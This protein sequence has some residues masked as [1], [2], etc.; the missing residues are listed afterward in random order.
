MA[1]QRPDIMPIIRDFD[2]LGA[3]G[4]DIYDRVN[5]LLRID[6]V[7]LT[8]SSV[9]LK[10]T[11][12]SPE[13]FGAGEFWADNIHVPKE[14]PLQ[15]HTVLWNTQ[16]RLP[17]VNQLC[18]LRNVRNW[19]VNGIN[20]EF[21]CQSIFMMHPKP[22][23]GEGDTTTLRWLE[24]FGGGFGGWKSAIRFLQTFSPFDNVRCVAVEH[25]I[26]AA[27]S[28]ALTHETGVVQSADPLPWDFFTVDQREW[29]ICDDVKSPKWL[30][31]ISHLGIDAVSISSPCPPWSSAGSA[32]G[33]AKEEGC[34]MLESILNCRFIKPSIIL[35]EQVANFAMHPHRAIITRALHGIGFRIVFQR[36]LNLHDVL[37][38]DRP[39]W[40]AL[41]VRVHSHIEVATVPSWIASELNVP[42]IDAVFHCWQSDTMQQLELT[43]DAIAIA[44]D[45][46]YLKS[47]DRVQ[48]SDPLKARTHAPGDIIPTFMRMY[49][50]QHELDPSNIVTAAQVLPLALATFKAFWPSDLSINHVMQQFLDSCW[51]SN[52]TCFQ[53]IDGGFFMS[54]LVEPIPPSL[55][56]E[57]ESLLLMVHAD[58]Q[59]DICW[60]PSP[61]C[62]DVPPGQC[63]PTMITMPTPMEVDDQTESATAT[64]QVI[65]KAK[66]C[67][68][69]GHQMF[70]FTSDM[71]Y[72]MMHVPWD[73]LFTPVA[74][75]LGELGAPTVELRY[76]PDRYVPEPV[77]SPMMIVLDDADV[78]LVQMPPAMPMIQ[79]AS[80]RHFPIPCDQFGPVEHDKQPDDH[81]I[82]MSMPLPPA[83]LPVL[84][85]LVVAAAAECRVTRAWNP[86]NDNFLI[87]IQG[88]T[89]PKQTL[90]DFWAGVLTPQMLQVLGRQVHVQCS[91]NQILISFQPSRTHGVCP[92]KPFQVTLAVSATRVMLDE[93]TKDMSSGRVLQLGWMQS[94]LWQGHFPADEAL[95][96]VKQ[97][98]HVTMLPYF[99]TKS[100]VMCSG[101]T[102][103]ASTHTLDSLQ[104]DALPVTVKLVATDGLTLRLQG[105]GGSKNQQRVY[106]QS[107]LASMLLEQGYD[108]KWTTQTVEA[109]LER[110]GLGKV[111]SITSQPMGGARLKQ[112]MQLLQEAKIELPKVDKPVSK[113][114]SDGLPW[115][116]KRKKHEDRPVDPLEFEICP[117]FF[118]GEDGSPLVQMSDIRPQANGL[119]LMSGSQATPWLQ[120]NQRTSNDELAILVIG[121]LPC[122]TELE[123]HELRF[124]CL[125][126]SKQMVLMSGVIVQLGNKK[127]AWTRGEGAKIDTEE[128]SLVALTVYRSDFSSDVWMD[129]LHKTIPTVKRLLSQDQITLHSV[130]GK[131][132]RNGRAQASPA[133]AESIQVHAAV[134]NAGLDDLLRS[135]GFNRVFATPKLP[136][137]RLSLQ[138]RVVWT[139]VEPSQA[140]CMAAK[141]PACL[142]LVKGKATLGYRVKLEDYAKAWEAL[143]PGVPVPQK[144]GGDLVYKAMGFP[145]GVT[146]LMV[147]KWLETIRWSATPFKALGP[148]GYLIR[149]ESHAPTGI[150][151]FNGSPILL[152]FL[153]EKDNGSQP[154]I[155]GPRG[156]PRSSVSNA[157]SGSD[158][159]QQP[160]QDPWAPMRQVQTARTLTGPTEQR[161]LAQDE[162][163]QAL[164]EDVKKLAQSH[165][166]MKTETVQ[167]INMLEKQTG[168]QF[169]V[170]TNSM[171]QLQ[172]EVDKGFKLSL[173]QN[174]QMMDSRMQELKQLLQRAP[175]RGQEE[176]L[177]TMTD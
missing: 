143:N 82:I 83:R 172:Q 3:R 157:S 68:E 119:C 137:G 126:G 175:K 142:G 86:V 4:S 75:S 18:W 100:F 30:S 141:V 50:Q 125:N 35:I 29:V 121:R 152:Q 111:Q 96:S 158:P 144:A 113:Q 102:Q 62:T 168:E 92:H 91:V 73:Q 166:S 8:E 148:T 103:V 27:V 5:V 51:T 127:V 28:Y 114:Q 146:S 37:K 76:D 69:Q 163:I 101:S 155:L 139:S 71:P 11:Q 32:P 160:G 21:D 169:A 49:G 24:L 72:E 78:T 44:S 84:P 124:P 147:Q 133:Q 167:K 43:D 47:S 9:V 36:T 38:I 129:L 60:F 16:Q 6:Q 12:Y 13:G 171:S 120:A 94:V 20:Y 165:E 99:G 14:T 136:T 117:N 22:C 154:V 134:P 66:L 176:D 93:V 7:H 115:K 25:D 170:I 97:V 88:P 61:V 118:T 130:W 174:T 164:Q 59:Q 48:L 156:P 89:V 2:I 150:H 67:L 42:V 106:Q 87:G 15:K 104:P 58:S 26:H 80:I 135:S 81:L 145:F 140:A 63:D 17:E 116:P 98:I 149:A 162:K 74:L 1:Y 40:F 34:L 105:G 45:P 19:D 70:W 109:V 55:L 33:L 132:L 41:A 64:F 112:L 79:H 110:F 177:P 56:T 151:L 108:L 57:F 159:F 173:Q 123:H 65:L 161:F 128:S 53:R 10:C 131:S 31:A 23:T 39:R 54:K 85:V 153:P 107:A 95:I 77:D 90:A 122:S 46:R 52:G 138:Y